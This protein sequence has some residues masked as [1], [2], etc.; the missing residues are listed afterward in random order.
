MACTLFGLTPEEALCGATRHAARALGLEAEI[1][2]LEVGK[3]ADFALWQ[4]ERPAELC[5]H[6]GANP[7]AGVV[8]RGTPRA[9]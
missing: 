2:T 1:G 7:C 9:G 5:Y 8:H 4:I 6:L 3:R